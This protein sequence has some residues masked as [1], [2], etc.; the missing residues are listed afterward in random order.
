LAALPALAVTVVTDNDEQLIDCMG[1]MSE[2]VGTAVLSAIENV[3][4]DAQPVI[5]FT[6]VQ[7]HAP[8]ESGPL[9]ATLFPVLG[10]DVACEQVYWYAGG[11]N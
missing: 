11:R 4:V 8:I 10:G 5:G 1:G 2:D 3:W 6:A 9:K 7:V